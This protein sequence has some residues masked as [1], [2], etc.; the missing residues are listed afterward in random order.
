[1]A[2]TA[3]TSHAQWPRACRKGVTQVKPSSTSP[4]VTAHAECLEPRR[5][6]TAPSFGITVHGRVFEDL[7]GDGRPGRGEPGL[8]GVTVTNN[9]APAAVTGDDSRFRFFAIGA[10]ATAQAVPPSGLHLTPG[11]DGIRTL[12]YPGGRRNAPVSAKPIPLTRTGGITGSVFYD[13]DGDGV[14]SPDALG[15]R[16]RPVFLDTNGDRLRQRSEPITRTDRRGNYF[17]GGLTPGAYRVAVLP[18][19]GWG[20]NSARSPVQVSIAD[21]EVI[22]DITFGL[23]W[24]GRGI[25]ALG[26]RLGSP[27]RG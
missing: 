20:F 24:V 5:L 12:V 7:D 25:P 17:F 27:R 4:R 10:L 14:P 19:G 16:G 22:N 1:M 13:L 23:E 21:G 8:A 11:D 15:L 18:G 3:A 26:S 2:D 9:G 6:M